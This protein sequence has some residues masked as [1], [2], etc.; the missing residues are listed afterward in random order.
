[1]RRCGGEVVALD[2]RQ[3]ALAND[4]QGHLP[5]QGEICGDALRLPFADGVFDLVFCQFTFLWID[6]QRVVKEIHVCCN[7]RVYWWPSSRTTAE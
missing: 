2:C 5:A 6:A 1:M 7:R 4:P 3:N